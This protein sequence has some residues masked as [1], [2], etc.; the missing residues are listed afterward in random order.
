[1]V[2]AVDVMSKIKIVAVHICHL[3][4]A[5]QTLNQNNAAVKLHALMKMDV[6]MFTVKIQQ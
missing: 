1:M 2:L 6:Q 5:Y 4:G 3:D